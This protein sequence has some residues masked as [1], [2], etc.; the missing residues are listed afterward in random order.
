MTT[1][2]N[3]TDP[4]DSPEDVEFWRPDLVPPD[5]KPIERA[6]IA[7]RNVRAWANWLLET[8]PAPEQSDDLKDVGREGEAGS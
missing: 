1:K 6:I 8:G 3:P 4:A 5:L 7:A 2:P